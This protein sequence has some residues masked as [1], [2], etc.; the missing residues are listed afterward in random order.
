VRTLKDL[1]DLHGKRVLARVDFNA[2][3]STGGGA[4]LEL[5]EGRAL[6]GVEALR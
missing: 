3:V 4:G 2:S 1:G 6:P 5:L